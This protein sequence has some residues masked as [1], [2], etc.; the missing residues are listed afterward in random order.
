LCIGTGG[1]SSVLSVV[2]GPL[3]LE[4]L[5]N[6]VKLISICTTIAFTDKGKRCLV[7]VKG[8]TQFKCILD[9]T[10]NRLVLLIRSLGY[11]SRPSLVGVSELYIM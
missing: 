8:L 7:F 2:A 4:A 1:I 6:R 5:V 11:Y 3:P 10:I 9:S